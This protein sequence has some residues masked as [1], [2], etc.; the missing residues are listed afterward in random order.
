MHSFAVF[1]IPVFVVPHVMHKRSELNDH[2]AVSRKPFPG[3]DQ[4]TKACNTCTF[5][6]SMHTLVKVGLDGA[7]HFSAMVRAFRRT[8]NACM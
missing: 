2:H 1:F 5:A 6:Q 3:G 7:T 4:K 8:R